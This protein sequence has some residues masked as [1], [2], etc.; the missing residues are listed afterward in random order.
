MMMIR[1]F[2]VYQQLICVVVA[3][4]ELTESTVATVAATWNLLIESTPL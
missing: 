1:T 2:K 4:E 3:A